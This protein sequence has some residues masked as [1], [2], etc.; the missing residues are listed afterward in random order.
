MLAPFERRTSL[1]DGLPLVK[2]GELVLLL[3]VP[4][5]AAFE[6]VLE[7]K[8]TADRAATRKMLG[9]VFP[10]HAVAAQFDDR[11]V[12]IRS[13]FRLLLLRRRRCRMRRS[14]AFVAR[15][16]MCHR[17]VRRESRIRHAVGR[18]SR[19]PSPWWWVVLRMRHV[20]LVVL[21]GLHWVIEKLAGML[22]LGVRLLMMVAVAVQRNSSVRRRC[23]ECD[24]GRSLGRYGSVVS[25]NT[26]RCRVSGRC[27]RVARRYWTAGPLQEGMDIHVDGWCWLG[28]QYDCV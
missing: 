22:R 3:F 15:S 17:D 6:I 28:C 16:S 14:M 26:A 8:A 27:A 25:T 19:V 2:S 12:L 4:L 18:V 10:L 20:L 23:T 7:A 5:G 11:R 21:H 1:K 9:N 24:Y 13:P